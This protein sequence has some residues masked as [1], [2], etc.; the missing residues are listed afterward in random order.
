VKPRVNITAL[1]LDLEYIAKAGQTPLLRKDRAGQSP[2]L[3]RDS[4]FSRQHANVSVIDESTSRSK[5]QTGFRLTSQATKY[6]YAHRPFEDR[7]TKGQREK[8]DMMLVKTGCKG[9][10][11]RSDERYINKLFDKQRTK[12]KDV[13]S[14]QGCDLTFAVRESVMKV[15]V[16]AQSGLNS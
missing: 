4:L 9:N 1:G 10:P 7:M 16:P 3:R 6:D 11:E 5:T 12:S 2:Q 8:E 14:T 13:G 15:G